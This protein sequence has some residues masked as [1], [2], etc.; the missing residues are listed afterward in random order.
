VELSELFAA[1]PQ[2]IR[3][4]EAVLKTAVGTCSI[5][6]EDD[7]GL[8]GL[9]GT[10]FH[11]QCPNES[12]L[13]AFFE[14]G[15]S[16]WRR[17]RIEKH[18]GEC[19]SCRE[20]IAMMVTLARAADQGD[21]EEPGIAGEDAI[22]TQLGRIVAAARDEEARRVRSK[23]HN[24]LSG[25][26]A[27]GSKMVM[28]IALSNRLVLSAVAL[29]L[30]LLAGPVVFWI[31]T[32]GSAVKEARQALIQAVMT[33]RRS[34]VM[35]SG[36]PYSPYTGVRGSGGRGDDLMFERAESK[37]SNKPSTPENQMA[38]ARVW[39]ARNKGD[40]PQKALEILDRITAGSGA[41]AQA[42]ND[43]GVAEFEL[44][45]YDRAITSFTTAL[46]LLPTLRE[47][48]FNRAVS[49][50][51][52]GRYGEAKTD[53]KRFLSTNPEPNWR[54]EAE[55]KLGILDLTPSPR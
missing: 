53:L 49:E 24:R 46:T 26:G 13:L 45:M 28:G 7:L 51:A 18:L 5:N 39:L 47:A 21:I 40:D 3:E 55:N 50:E 17:A 38:L 52:S 33:G 2:G 48:L 12:E 31:V 9:M 34:E 16:S 37:I 22:Q 54:Q 11:P 32:G 10:T 25:L 1:L 44:T 8:S 6:Q 42:W 23:R 36:L 41:S 4:E 14:R 19:P 29:L 27:A 20:S 43:K 30:L 15:L 35:V